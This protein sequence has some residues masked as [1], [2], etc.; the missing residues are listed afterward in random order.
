MSDILAYLPQV[1]V[2]SDL[3][4]SNAFSNL[5]ITDHVLKIYRQWD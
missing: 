4:E 1:V 3:S 5:N 2:M